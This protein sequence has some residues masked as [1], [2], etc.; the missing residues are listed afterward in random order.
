MHQKISQHK[1]L[2]MGLK[3]ETKSIKRAQKATVKM[4]K[5]GAVDCKMKKGGKTKKGGC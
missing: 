2:A 4:A 5:G 3:G 1:E